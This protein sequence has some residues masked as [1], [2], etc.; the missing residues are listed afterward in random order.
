MPRRHYRVTDSTNAR[1]RTLAARAVPHGTVV[2]AD[3]Q[4]AGRGRQG[5]TWVS[6]PGSALL[7]SVLIR[8]L[9]DSPLLPLAVP[10]AVCEA[11]EAVAPVRCAVKWPNDVWIDGR[12]VCGVLIEARPGEGWAAAGIGVN[13][14]PEAL[15]PGLGER[16]TAVGHGVGRERLLGVLL[17]ALQRRVAPGATEAVLAA[18]AERDGLRGREV[19]WHG[20]SGTAAGI[21]DNGR[22]RVETGETIT[23]INA[24]EVHLVAQE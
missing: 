1:L 16:A 6:P 22:L 13:L 4:T 7:C 5:R 21:D 12:K 17:T 23:N 8:R 3:E 19:R 24:G 15:D 18:F 20:G 11:I 14:D 9:T 10:V 2:T